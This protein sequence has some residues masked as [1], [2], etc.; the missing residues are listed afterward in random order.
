MKERRLERHNREKETRKTNKKREIERGRG[1]KV[2][3]F[4]V[5]SVK[6]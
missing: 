6:L 3:A 2:L 4:P 5:F 1:K